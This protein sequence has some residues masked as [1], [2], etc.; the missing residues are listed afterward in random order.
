[1]RRGLA[2]IASGAVLALLAAVPAAATQYGS[3]SYTWDD[4]GSYECG[5]DNWIDWQASGTGVLSIRTGSGPDEGA[6][7][8][9]DRYRWQSVDTRRSDGANLYFSGHGNAIETRAE[10]IEGSTFQFWSISAGA[11]FMVLD[12]EGNVLAR[13]RGSIRSSIIFDTE[14]DATPGG[15]LVEEVSVEVSGPHPGLEF[16]PCSYFG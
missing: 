7:F 1:V 6:F 2:V 12:G 5:P 3:E 8:A 10:R 13:D 9:H 16:D 15:I 11:P 14:G 4:Q